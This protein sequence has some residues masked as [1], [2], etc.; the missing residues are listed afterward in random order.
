V[1]VVVELCGWGAGCWT[2]ELSSED[3]VVVEEGSPAHP[4]KVMRA[5]PIKYKRG[6]FFIILRSGCLEL[7]HR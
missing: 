5:V 6:V 3:V 4:D 1:V 7:L 2:D